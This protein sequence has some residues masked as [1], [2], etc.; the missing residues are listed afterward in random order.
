[1]DESSLLKQIK[2]LLGETN[3]QFWVHS[4]DLHLKRCKMVSTYDCIKQDHDYENKQE[5]I[6]IY[7]IDQTSAHQLVRTEL[8]SVK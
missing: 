1:M 4:T 3:S 8:I 6:A 2:N 7:T 5:K